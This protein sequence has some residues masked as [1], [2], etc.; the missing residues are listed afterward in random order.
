[1]SHGLLR[2]LV[3]AAPT[4]RSSGLRAAWEPVPEIVLTVL[5]LQID[6]P[7]RVVLGVGDVE[8][9]SSEAHSLRPVE[10]G[11][12][13]AAV[14]EPLATRADLDR[15]FAVQVG[16]DDPVVSGVGDEQS[17]PCPIGQDLSRIEQRAVVC[18]VVLGGKLERREIELALE[19]RGNL[20]D[21][22]VEVLERDFAAP[23]RANRPSGVIRTRVG[24]LDT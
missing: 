23:R 8:G 9:L 2:A 21:H 19:L 20:T 17:V 24:Q 10:A 18:T 16:H 7:D 14:D 22:A 12:L 5:G 6:G 4:Y 13:I 1:M 15:R 11:L 3:L